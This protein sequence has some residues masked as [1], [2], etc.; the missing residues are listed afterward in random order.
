MRLRALIA[1]ILAALACAVALNGCGSSAVAIDPLAR[2]ADVTAHAG[3]A[4]MQL[5]ARIESGLLPDAVTMAGGGYFNYTT[6]EGTFSLQL[7]GLPSTAGL[8]SDAT[9]QEIFK[10]STLYLSSPCSPASS[11]T[12]PAG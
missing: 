10:G 8:E 4:H 6:H 5:T 2:A 9:I 11:R 1:V 12:G 3:G 7:T